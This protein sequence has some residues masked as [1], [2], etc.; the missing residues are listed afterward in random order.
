M[1]VVLVSNCLGLIGG[2][3]YTML[4]GWLTGGVAGQRL[5]VS[6]VRGQDSGRRHEI[7]CRETGQHRV[8]PSD[9]GHRLEGPRTVHLGDSGTS[10]GRTADSTPRRLGD[11]GWKD[12]GQ[13]R[14]TVNTSPIKTKLVMLHVKGIATQ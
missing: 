7:Q 3:H 1:S 12:R 11:I 13:Y 14:C 6:D 2:P 4:V 8:E 9:Q 5:G 10:A